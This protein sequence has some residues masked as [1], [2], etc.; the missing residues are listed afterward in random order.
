V[1]DLSFSLWLRYRWWSSGLKCH[2]VF[3]WLLKW[4]LQLKYGGDTFY[5]AGNQL[6]DYMASHPRQPKS[7]LA[8]ARWSGGHF[9]AVSFVFVSKTTE[10]FGRWFC[11]H[12]QV[13][14]SIRWHHWKA[15][16]QWTQ[17]FNSLKPSGMY[18]CVY[19]T[20][21]LKISEVVF[22]VYVFRTILTANSDYFLKQPITGWSL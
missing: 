7:K 16:S 14:S 21:A 17:W 3:R 12:H 10:R 15:L 18:V 11:F 1:W 8:Y 20:A 5:N 6:K 2:V 9:R 4:P 22:C 13:S 19:I